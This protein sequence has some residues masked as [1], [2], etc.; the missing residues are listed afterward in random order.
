MALGDCGQRGLPVH[1]LYRVRALDKR[2]GDSDPCRCQVVSIRRRESLIL[3]GP[4]SV[5]SPT[6]VI[7]AEPCLT[8]GRWTERLRRKLDFSPFVGGQAA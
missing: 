2:D 6:D 3:P 7:T 4:R 1:L 5:V 8:N